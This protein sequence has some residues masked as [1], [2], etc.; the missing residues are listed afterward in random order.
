MFGHSSLPPPPPHPHTAQLEAL[1]LK[2]LCHEMS[3][4]LKV[5]NIKYKI[6]FL[7]A[8]GFKNSGENLT[9]FIQRL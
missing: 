3:I 2:G 8:G 9:F 4:F 7:S 6:F 1:F 5:Y